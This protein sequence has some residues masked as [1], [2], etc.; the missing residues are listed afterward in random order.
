MDAMNPDRHTSGVPRVSVVLATY[1]RPALVERLLKQLGTQTLP[2]SDFEVIVVDDGSIPPVAPRLR[3]LE[4]PYALIVLVQA[5]AGAARARHHGI[6]HARGELLVL[7]DD[8]M[9]IPPEFLTEHL[10]LHQP[11]VPTAVIGRYRDDP[12]IAAMPLFER[13]YSAKWRQWSA[14]YARGAP[15]LGNALCTGNAS[16]KRSDYLA[17]GGFDLSLDRSEDADLGLKLE[18]RGVKLLYSEAAYTLH[19]S[20]HIQPR[21]FLARAYRYGIC[22]LRIGRKHT[23]QLHADPWR[24]LFMLPALGRPL[25]AGPLLAPELA[26]PLAYGAMYLAVAADRLRLRR[27]ALRGTGLAFGMEYFRGIRSECGS[28]RKTFGSF[29][30]YMARVASTPE[31]PPVVARKLYLFGRLVRDID[32]DHGW[33]EDRYSRNPTTHRSLLRD[34]IEKIG[35]QMAIGVRAIAFCRDARMELLAKVLSRSMRY[36]YGSDIHWKAQFAPGV[37]FV[38][39]MGL[40]ISGAARIGPRCVLGQNVTLGMGRDP[41]T[42]VDGA[43][44]LEENVRVGNNATLFGPITIGAGSKILPGVVLSKSVPKASLVE[45]PAPVVRPRAGANRSQ[46]AAPL[47][48]GAREPALEEPSAAE[49]PGAGSEPGSGVEAPVPSAHSRQ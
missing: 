43:P 3:A 7:L 12:Q 17:V 23:Q 40:A 2:P 44:T 11:G 34:S 25:L 32:D 27:L 5:N 18:E 15:V 16:L 35:M 22:E 28:L 46:S 19:G 38:H 13:W 4:L 48:S 47:R 1:N 6:L 9:Q 10:R 45:P 41:Q 39:G 30:D 49:Q 33:Y 24:W 42:G 21:Q 37:M 36:V 20:D 29:V 14:D 26:R 8:D 31:A